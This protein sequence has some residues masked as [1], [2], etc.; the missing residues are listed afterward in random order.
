MKGLCKHVHWDRSWIHLRTSQD[1]V[2]QWN[3]LTT[4]LNA[5]NYGIRWQWLVNH[6]SELDRVYNS[7]PGQ[8]RHPRVGPLQRYQAIIL[9]EYADLGP[10]EEEMSRMVPALLDTMK[11]AKETTLGEPLMKP[12]NLAALVATDV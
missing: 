4:Y 11:L 2:D 7:A 12:L 6:G 5:L 1:N 3:P 8:E 10:K 9:D